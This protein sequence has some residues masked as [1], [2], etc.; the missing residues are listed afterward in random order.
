MKAITERPGSAAARVTCP[1]CEERT[2]CFGHGADAS[3]LR[4]LDQAVERRLSLAAGEYLYRIGDPFRSLYAVRSGCL[5]NSFRDEKGR[6]HVMGFHMPGDVVGVGGIETQAY[7]FDLCALEPSGVCEVPFDKLEALA[8]RVP[9]LRRNIAKIFGRYRNRDARTQFLRREDSAEARVAGF[10][11]DF[12][13]RFEERGRDPASLRLPMSRADIGDYLG[14]S[15]ASV[16]RA[17]AR[18][19]ARGIAKVWRRTIKVSSIEGLR[20]LAAGRA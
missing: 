20:S 1:S 5:K 14:L 10:L 4:Q 17:F 6:D 16:G 18:L 12:C 19:G 2:S 3:A 8:H 13:R 9:A 15:A 7:I 11:L